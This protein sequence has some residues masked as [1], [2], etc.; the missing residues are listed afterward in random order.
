MGRGRWLKRCS[1]TAAARG[2]GEGLQP[3]PRGRE[4]LLRVF[5]VGFSTLLGRDV[6]L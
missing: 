2:D 1:G 6:H 4:G 5:G 3:S